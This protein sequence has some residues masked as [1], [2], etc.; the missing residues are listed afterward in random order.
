MYEKYKS[1]EAHSTFCKSESHWWSLFVERLEIPDEK[2]FLLSMQIIIGEI[3][4][5]IMS[6]LVA[7]IC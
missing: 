5:I 2:R 6:D 4:D 7:S 1:Q 3:S